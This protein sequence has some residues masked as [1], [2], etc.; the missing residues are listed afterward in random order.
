MHVWTRAVTSFSVKGKEHSSSITRVRTSGD[1][2]VSNASFRVELGVWPAAYK[3]TEAAA[4][5]IHQAPYRIPR[6]SAA[7]MASRNS[8]K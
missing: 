7:V 6:A 8:A 2:L 1:T 4:W 3:G 5:K